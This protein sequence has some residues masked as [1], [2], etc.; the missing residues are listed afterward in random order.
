MLEVETE[1]DDFLYHNNEYVKQQYIQYNLSVKQILTL[2][3]QTAF[4]NIAEKR[5]NTCRSLQ[6]ISSYTQ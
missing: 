3:H 5:R 6:A 4:K 1:I 2:L